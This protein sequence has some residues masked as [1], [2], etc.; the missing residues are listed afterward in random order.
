MPTILQ[1]LESLG[2]ALSALFFVFL[3][4]ELWSRHRR[5]ALRGETVRE[6]LGSASVL[7]P[8]LALGA[9]TTAFIVALFGAASLLAIT[10]LPTTPLSALACLVL[11]DFLYYVDHT[12][13]HRIRAYWAV[14]HSV[15]H[16][17]PQYDQTTALRVSFVDGYT[18]PWFQLPAVVLGFDP[19]LVLACFGVVITYQ[20]WI[21]TETIGRLGWLD[22]IFMTPS[23]HR[24]HHSSLPEHLDKNYGGVLVVWDRLFGTYARESGPVTYGLTKPIASSHPL[25]IHTAELV[26]L[27]DDLRRAPSAMER[28][29][30]VVSGPEYEPASWSRAHGEPTAHDRH[31]E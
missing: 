4:F 16:S 23:N 15:H 21:H 31:D 20:Q 22:D 28:F 9:A 18:S 27:W 13:G 1:L 12:A 14:S 2:T 7:L 29:R 30:M 24:V 8:T 6:M 3:P 5:E 19:V 25:H 11:C 17:S 26:R 10:R